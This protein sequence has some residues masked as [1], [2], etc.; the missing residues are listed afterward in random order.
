MA[1]DMKTSQEPDHDLIEMATNGEEPV[2]PIII[3]LDSYKDEH[4]VNLTW[5]TWMVIL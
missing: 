5:K 1:T 2:L 4:H 3:R